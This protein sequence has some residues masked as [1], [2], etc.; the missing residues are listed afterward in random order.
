MDAAAP[1]RDGVAGRAIPVSHHDPRIDTARLQRFFSAF[2][3]STRKPWNDRG[4]M[5]AD[6]KSVWSWRPQA[7][8]KACGGV[9]ARPGARID[10]PQGDGG[11][12]ASLPEESAP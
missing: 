4:G 6:G 12:S 5:S 8:V 11:K 9:A 3:A 7:G 1:A 2:G 10:E